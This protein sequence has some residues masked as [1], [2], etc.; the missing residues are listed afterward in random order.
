MKTPNQGG[1]VSRLPKTEL[2]I[3]HDA[4]IVASK[5]GA[6]LPYDPKGE[7]ER[8][9]EIDAIQNPVT[10]HE[11]LKGYISQLQYTWEALRARVP[12][13]ILASA[14]SEHIGRDRFYLVGYVGKIVDIVIQ[15]ELLNW[16]ESWNTDASVHEIPAG[17]AG[18]TFAVR[19][20][21]FYDEDGW[22][23]LDEELLVDIPFSKV[24][25]IY[26]PNDHE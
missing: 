3:A 26:L 22:E 20:A 23:H 13:T 2:D 8:F 17:V 18:P 12:V 21:D 16:D 5:L 7:A 1:N 19:A 4:L 15:N 11:E 6:R 9:L 10:R 24:H 14:Y 25:G